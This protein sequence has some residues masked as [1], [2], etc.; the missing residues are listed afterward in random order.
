[1][2]YSFKKKRKHT[3]MLL[4]SKAK[5]TQLINEYNPPQQNFILFM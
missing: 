2:S 4:V 1:M 5:I 3:Q